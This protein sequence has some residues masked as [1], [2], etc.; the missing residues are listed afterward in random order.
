MVWQGPRPRSSL[1]TIRLRT[2]EQTAL[3]RRTP[4]LILR[5]L[6]IMVILSWSQVHSKQNTYGYP[7]EMSTASKLRN[8]TPN[9]LKPIV[10]DKPKAKDQNEINQL[11]NRYIKMELAYKQQAMES[12]INKPT[13]LL[14]RTWYLGSSANWVPQ[15]NSTQLLVTPPLEFEIFWFSHSPGSRC[16]DFFQGLQLQVHL[17]HHMMTPSIY[18]KGGWWLTI[19]MN[20]LRLLSKRRRIGSGVCAAQT[21]F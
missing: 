3:H 9:P 8:K 11:L 16:L 17:P 12:N 5:S 21:C 18:I 10:A 7:R 20:L 19:S 2:C 13:C 15:V 1:G 4:E 14:A 6:C